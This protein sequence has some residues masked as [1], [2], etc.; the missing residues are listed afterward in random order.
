MIETITPAVCGSRRRHRFALAA[1]A[2]GA[3]AAAALLGAALGLAGSA[4]GGRNA[5]L[6][7][8]ALAALAAARELG[9]VRVPLPQVRL[10]VPERWHHELPLPVWATGYGAGLGIGVA[11]YQPVATFW[12]ACAAAVALGRPLAAGIA[13]SL[14]GAGRALMVA[15]PKRRDPDVTAAVETLARH[16]PALLRA[17]GVALAL[18]A[19]ALVAAPAAGAVPLSLGPGSQLDPSPSRGVLSYTQ[20]DW[21]ENS[22]I[23]HVSPGDA[24]R[25]PGAWGPALD[26]SLLAYADAGGVRVVHWRSGSEVAQ[27]AGATKPAL[28]WPW[29]AYRLDAADGTRELWLR[30]LSTGGMRLVTRVGSYVDIGRPAIRGGRV[31]WSGAAGNGSW[32]RLYEIAS[33]R[34]RIVA[35]SSVALLAFPSLTARRIVWVEQRSRSSLLR[36]RR[37]DG[38]TVSTL[39]RTYGPGE[40][41][42]S[43]GLA[44]RTAYVAV[45]YPIDGYSY[46]ERIGF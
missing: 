19:V 14:Y 9:L 38:Q 5:A 46:L 13:F 37:L 44:G 41:F 28:A 10:Q 8:A 43:T 27:V 6:A 7:A 30:N 23:V 18:Y 20:R 12:V 22:V 35:R 16:R 33:G 24:V 32:I 26:G 21:T 45:W 42:W 2:V 17:N 31:A 4:L 34:R 39:A 11:T 25:Y 40:V 1:F 15:L 29:L 3:I 36:M